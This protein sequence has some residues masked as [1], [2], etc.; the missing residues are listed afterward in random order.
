MPFDDKLRT[1]VLLWADRH[2]CYCKKPCG[3]NIE[4]HHIV[5]E[6]SEGSNE[7]E[8]ALPLCFDCH[9]EVQRYNDDH[10]RGT[11]FKP[12]ELRARREQVFEEFTR[13]LVPPIHYQVTQALPGGGS[14]TF[15][16]VGFVLAHLGDSMPVKVRIMV[17]TVR[18]DSRGTTLDG[19]YGGS[20][21]WRLNPRFTVFGHFTMPDEKR[22][23]S[24]PIQLWIDVSIID[25]YDRSHNL[26][27][28]EYVYVPDKNSWYL[29]P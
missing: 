27:P 1:K 10:P 13:H 24:D 15:P 16:D 5:P 25:Q 21:L 18:A 8:N 17:H 22:L 2:C 19:Y 29:E 9:S 6:S 7:V 4:V 11:K 23:P 20:K 3:V 28:V 26:L 12:D 14:R